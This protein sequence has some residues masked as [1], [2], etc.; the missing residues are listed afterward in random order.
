MTSKVWTEQEAKRAAAIYRTTP[1]R[2]GYGHQKNAVHFIA[3]ELKRSKESVLHRLRKHGET[4]EG[5][6]RRRK[7]QK[8]EL[9]YRMITQVYVPPQTLADRERRYS[10]EHSTIIA[11]ICGDPL[12]GY[13]AL[14]RK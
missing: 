11:S 6:D 12:P 10:L 9:P 3:R 8:N 7:R 14:D 13:S 4:F 5:L 2:R 1:G